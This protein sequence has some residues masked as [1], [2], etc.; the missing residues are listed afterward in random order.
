MS[1]LRAPLKPLLEDRLP[2]RDVQ[3]I[4]RKLQ[5]RPV[6]R[7]ARVWIWPLTAA[8]ALSVLFVGWWAIAPGSDA[9]GPLALAGQSPLPEKR[10]FGGEQPTR[11]AMA[12]GSRIVL[13][14]GAELEVVDNT[15]RE[16]R[17]RM[18]RG[19]G[20][21]EVKPGGPRRWRVDCGVLSVEVVGTGFTIDRGE[22]GVDVRVTHGV[23]AVRGAGVPGGVQRL[24]AGQSLAVS[25][26]ASV[27]RDRAATG[28]A[29]QPPMASQPL[30][31]MQP[32]ATV[33]PGADTQS[34]VAT[35]RSAA[36]QPSAATKPS[37]AMQPP[38]LPEREERSGRLGLQASTVKLAANGGSVARSSDRA[39]VT[40]AADPTLRPATATLTRMLRDA[41]AARRAG[42][43][44]QAQVL[45][46]QVL[47]VAPNTRYA[48]LAALT[49]GRMRMESDPLAA[50]ASLR[51]ALAAGPPRD[52]REDTLARLVEA[53]ARAGRMDLAQKAAAEYRSTFPSGRRAAEVQSWIAAP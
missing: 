9:P 52:L 2:E 25:E 50:A 26:P 37:V 41:D 30:T 18:Q 27:G 21:F 34:A 10:T 6:S 12:D 47:R 4:W 43:A 28:A 40:S 20:V 46:E 35:R 36:A 44:R 7:P 23:V 13:E 53:Y 33:Q 3:R 51:A 15:G 24:G 48:S 19:R 38:V 16:F 8:G 17:T 1:K 29:A 32:E 31:I 49:L 11:L 14:Q 5:A 45:L 39:R 42:D 22:R